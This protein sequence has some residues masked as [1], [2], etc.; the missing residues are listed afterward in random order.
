MKTKKL[1]FKSID[2]TFCTSLEKHIEEAKLEELKTITLVEA[3][4]DFSNS[5]Y[6]WC[7]HQGEIGEREECKKSIC[8]FYSSKSGRGICEHRG[9]LYQHGEEVTFDVTDNNEKFNK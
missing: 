5:E 4:P 3:I 8:E 2:D 9:K 7:G 6:I 1:Y